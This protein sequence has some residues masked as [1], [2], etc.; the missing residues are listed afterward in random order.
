MH[1]CVFHDGTELCML[2]VTRDMAHEKG[3]EVLIVYTIFEEI[4]N[5][6]VHFYEK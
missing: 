3:N 2:F 5:W 4:T 6:I 1:H